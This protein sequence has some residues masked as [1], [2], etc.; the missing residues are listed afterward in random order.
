[1]PERLTLSDLLIQGKN[2]LKRREVFKHKGRPKKK[3]KK[4]KI[5]KKGKKKEKRSDSLDT[6]DSQRI[7]NPSSPEC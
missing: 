7:L 6:D 3:K 1:M 2:K 5:E 4:K